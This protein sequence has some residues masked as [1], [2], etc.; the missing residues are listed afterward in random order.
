MVQPPTSYTRFLFHGSLNDFLRSRQKNTWLDFPYR[1]ASTVKDAIEA[2]GVPHAEVRKIVVNGNEKPVGYL[3]Q[4]GDE[5]EVFPYEPPFPAGDAT[6]FVLDVHLGGLARRL[7]MLGIDTVYRNNLHDAE[8][9][10]FATTENRIV[11]T[12]DVGL[13]KHKVLRW[14]YW[15]RSQQTEDQ[16]I[17]VMNRFSL[18]NRL[19]PFLRCIACNGL[20]AGVEKKEIVSLV[21]EKTR[22]FFEDFY[23]CTTCGKIYW[24]GSHYQHMRHAIKRIRSVACQ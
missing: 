6:G 4:P 11:L 16:L 22:L 13:L 1:F 9:I 5:T 3:L 8:I 21:P 14:G 12:R 23:R 17:E 18:C 19:Q 2:T 7:R 20:L 15:L 10:A 24:K